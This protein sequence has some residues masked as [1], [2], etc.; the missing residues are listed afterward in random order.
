LDSW[1][2]SLVFQTEFNCAIFTLDNLI[3]CIV[4]FMFLL[5]LKF[6]I[7]VFVCKCF[8]DVFSVVCL[9]TFLCLLE[10]ADSG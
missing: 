10:D 8:V 4:H 3:N 6:Y 1:L 2:F 5:F 9:Y 7:A